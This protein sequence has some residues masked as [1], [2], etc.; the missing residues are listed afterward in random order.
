MFQNISLEVAMMKVYNTTYDKIENKEPITLAIG[1]FDGFHIGHQNIV[2]KTKGYSDTKSAVMTFTPHPVSVITKTNLPTLMDNHDKTE[3]LASSAVDH[4]FIVHFTTEFSR[5]SAADFIHF[6]K[7][8]NVKRIVVGRDFKFGYRGLGTVHNL[9]KYFE[10][11]LVQDLLYKNIRVSST[12]IKSLLDQGN[13]RLIKTLLGRSY[14]I[15]GEVVHGDKV[16]S[17]IGYPT[18][19]VDYKNYYVP[20]VGIYVVRVKIGDKTY[21]GCANLGHN[22]TLNYS[23]TKRLEV[24]IIDFKG[25]LYNQEITVS[26]E[27]YLRDEIKFETVDELLKQID[28]DVKETIKLASKL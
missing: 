19:N 23:T 5:L 27:Y 24:F 14:Q 28:K 16:G 21:L 17:L 15:H 9:E 7:R 6:L 2:S 18:A 10:V 8:I 12:Y 22:P 26:F 11:D 20:K 1:N 25:D 4:F 13:I 3:F